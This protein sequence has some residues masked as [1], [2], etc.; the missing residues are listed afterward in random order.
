M[1]EQFILIIA[2]FLCGCLPI[3]P[4]STTTMDTVMV[5]KSTQIT[6]GSSDREAVLQIMGEPLISS[7]F[8]GI[9]VFR[10]SKIRPEEGFVFFPFIPLVLGFD[11]FRR[12]TL[13]TYNS[14]EIVEYVDSEVYKKSND[15]TI[16]VDAGAFTLVIDDYDHQF[17][18][19]DSNEIVKKENH[20]YG[21]N[22]C[23]VILGCDLEQDEPNPN[24][25]RTKLSFDDGEK[26]YFPSNPRQSRPLVKGSLPGG[27]H[28]LDISSEVFDKASSVSFDCQEDKTLY[29]TINPIAR[30]VE[31]LFS[32]EEIQWTFAISDEPSDIFIGHPFLIFVDGKW[33]TDFDK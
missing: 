3:Y 24:I 10:D 33:I 23:I 6:L 32:K 7:R 16:R 1:A 27:R 26:F 28:T 2:G 4:T 8:W 5:D 9:D 25:C 30:T 21:S 20:M 14:D 11:T 19:A 18:V 22:L 12:D 15:E 29:I 17:V 13:V 31:K